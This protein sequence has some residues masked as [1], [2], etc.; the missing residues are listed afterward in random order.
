MG[1]TTTTTT[2]TTT[3]TQTC[4]CFKFSF[5]NALNG[6]GFFTGQILGLG[7]NVTDAPATSVEILTRSDQSLG[8]GEYIGRPLLNVFTVRDCNVTDF[9]FLSAGIINQAPAVLDALLFLDSTELSGAVFRAGVAP[10]PGPFVTGSGFVDTEDINL[11]FV[12]C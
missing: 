2:T 3:S 11:T 5:E 4:D 10:N 8:I 12:P 1:T 9:N 7:P 6:G